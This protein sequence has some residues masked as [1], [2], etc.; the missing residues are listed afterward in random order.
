MRRLARV[1]KAIVTAIGMAVALVLLVP[2]ESIPERW[3]PIVG[4]VLAVGTV[5]GVY[6]VRNHQPVTREDL[7]R[8][9]DYLARP[10]RQHVRREDRGP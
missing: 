2:Q 3:R 9:V 5:V 4:L 6:K 10:P 1:R 7:Q 8:R